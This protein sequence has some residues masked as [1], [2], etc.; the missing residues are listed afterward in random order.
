MSCLQESPDPVDAPRAQ[1]GVSRAT[2]CAT[3]AI[4]FVSMVCA[5]GS[6][7]WEQL[8][9]ATRATSSAPGVSVPFHVLAQPT[10]IAPYPI[11]GSTVSED[12]LEAILAS[13]RPYVDRSKTLGRMPLSIVVHACRL[14]G[15]EARFPGVRN[16][17]TV[18]TTLSGEEMCRTLLVH[19]EFTRNCEVRSPALLMKSAYGIRTLN[20]ADGSF[21]AEETMTH[22][23]KLAQVMAEVGMPTGVEVVTSEG[24]VGTLR[25]IIQDDAARLASGVELEFAVAGLCRYARDGHP[26]TNRFGQEYSFERVANSLLA[27]KTGQGTCGGAHVPH[28]LTMLMRADQEKQLLTRGTRERIRRHLKMI[29]AAL[30]SSQA[31]NGAWPWNWPAYCQNHGA[32]LR[33][34]PPGS[35]A[36]FEEGLIA[37]GHHLEWIAFAPAD[38]RP[39]PHAIQSAA[40]YL[41][42]V[43]PKVAS[44]LDRDWHTYN[45][46][47]HAARA[48]LL[49]SG[50]K[51]CRDSAAAQ[52]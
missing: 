31:P 18:R 10:E 3:T 48:L 45:P 29:A 28:A 49:I 37:T 22:F 11:K 12:E 42:S 20:T 16:G 23:G 13:L 17:R 46:A 9:V 24:Y 52:R 51:H 47:S 43:W 44:N 1:S 8:A 34:E 6:V 15:R 21:V 25:E 33:P 19:E 5:W 14:W 27:Q 4:L 50:L 2:L 26:W 36:I 38:C 32:V 40:R 39:S 41:V 7:R 30:E 35:E